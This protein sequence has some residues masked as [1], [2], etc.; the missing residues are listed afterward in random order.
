MPSPPRRRSASRWTPNV[1]CFA[2]RNRSNGVRI[3]SAMKR[4]ISFVSRVVDASSSSP[5]RSSPSPPSRSSSSSSPVLFV[6]CC[7]SFLSVRF[8]S[9]PLRKSLRSRKY[10]RLLFPNYRYV[11]LALK[12]IFGTLT[13]IFVTPHY[14]YFQKKEE[15]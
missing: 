2:R 11:D 1:R 14:S 5:S 15:S 4:I 13:I 8:I 6:Y 9:F 7:F 12:G 10:G 3:S